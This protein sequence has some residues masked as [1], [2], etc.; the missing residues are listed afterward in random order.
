MRIIDN[1]NMK[2]TVLVCSNVHGSMTI[3]AW[4]QPL[5]IWLMWIIYL[6]IKFNFSCSK[7][8]PLLKLYFL[9]NNLIIII[10]Y[11]FNI[12]DR[13]NFDNKLAKVT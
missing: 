12:I 4:Q 6:A 8:H 5:Y 1:Q 3:K 13:C 10:K 9:I 7:R 2:L 11:A